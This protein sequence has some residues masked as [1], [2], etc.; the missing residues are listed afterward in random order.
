MSRLTRR[1]FFETFS[2]GRLWFETIEQRV[3]F[4]R[5]QLRLNKR[6]IRG[7]RESELPRN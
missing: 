4:A 1:G 2:D 5:D 3:V 7:A 6:I